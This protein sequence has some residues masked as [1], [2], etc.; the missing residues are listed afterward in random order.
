MLIKNVNV[1]WSNHE[2][3]YIYLF[4]FIL[5]RKQTRYKLKLLN[6]VGKKIGMCNLGAK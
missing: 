2:F 6:N 3:F 1:L 5:L 4:I